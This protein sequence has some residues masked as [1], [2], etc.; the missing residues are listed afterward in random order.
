M[1]DVSPFL[2]LIS[3]YEILSTSNAKAGLFAKKFDLISTLN[4]PIDLYLLFLTICKVKSSE[5]DSIPTIV[6]NLH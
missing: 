2:P 6:S 3:D 1:F 5:L 4:T